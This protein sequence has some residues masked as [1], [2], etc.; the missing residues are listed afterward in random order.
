MSRILQRAITTSTYGL[1][2]DYYY[3]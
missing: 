2:R 3:S 1:L